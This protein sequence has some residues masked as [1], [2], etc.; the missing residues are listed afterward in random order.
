LYPLSVDNTNEITIQKQHQQTPRRR[1]LFGTSN[2]NMS[3]DVASVSPTTSSSL[4]RTPVNNAHKSISNSKQSSPLLRTTNSNISYQ[5]EETLSDE[6]E[7]RSDYDSSVEEEITSEKCQVEKLSSNMDDEIENLLDTQENVD[8]EQLQIRFKKLKTRCECMKKEISAL[9]DKHL[10]LEQN[11][12]RK[13]II[14]TF[15]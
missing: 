11:T 9:K 14:V 8:L 12:I 3:F 6:E 13:L 4:T 7:L 15:T 1:K 5:V 10:Q 2:T